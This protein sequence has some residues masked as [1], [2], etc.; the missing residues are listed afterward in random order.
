MYLA[1]SALAAMCA[2]LAAVQT[3]NAKRLGADLRTK[4]VEA[5]S[6][7]LAA[8]TMEDRLHTEEMARMQLADRITK[9][10]TALR[11]SEDTGLPSAAGAADRTEEV[12]GAA[13]RTRLH[14]G[15][16]R[17]GNQRDV[18]RPQRG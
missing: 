1:I 18:E 17:R 5:E 10:E 13:G 3:R 4:T 7:Q 9:V 8:R 16:T 15:C 14:Q 2:I 12:Q 11:E 6:F